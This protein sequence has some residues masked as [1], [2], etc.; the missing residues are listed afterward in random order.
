MQR[1]AAVSDTRTQPRQAGALQIDG[2]LTA[3][4]KLRYVRQ[5]WQLYALILPVLVFFAIFHYWPM[6][7]VQIAFKD[8]LGALG[9]V[10]SP[11]VGFKHFFIVLIIVNAASRR[12][13]GSSLW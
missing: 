13:T 10:G 1:N 8:F 12:F 2:R 11:C 5:D 9:I 4:G 3:R 6:Y 7:G